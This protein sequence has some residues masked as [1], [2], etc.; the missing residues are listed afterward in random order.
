MVV[1]GTKMDLVSPRLQVSVRCL[2]L[3][4]HLY[5]GG[6]AGSLERN[7]AGARNQVGRAVLRDV[8]K[9]GMACQRGIQPP[10][11]E[12]A[13]TVSRRRPKEQEEATRSMFDHVK[14]SLSLASRLLLRSSLFMLSPL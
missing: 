4:H 9:E 5:A 6:R 3:T 7:N 12:H 14:R 2:S 10:S 8:C 1:V 11:C 13:E